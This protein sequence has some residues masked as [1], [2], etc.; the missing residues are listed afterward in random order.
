MLGDGA[1]VGVKEKVFD[2]E[3]ID[4]LDQLLRSFL[5]LEQAT[6]APT[7]SKVTIDPP[8]FEGLKRRSRVVAKISGIRF[9]RA[10]I[11]S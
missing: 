7:S 10:S 3:T 2:I 4:D 5:I 11:S 9:A 8:L 1:D 6:K